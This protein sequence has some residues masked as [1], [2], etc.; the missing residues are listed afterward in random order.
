M[1][2]SVLWRNEL[3]RFFHQCHDLQSLRELKYLKQKDLQSMGLQPDIIMCRTE[4]PL[5]TEI[6]EK[7]ALFC[8]VSCNH[9]LQNLDAETLYEVPL[10]GSP[11]FDDYNINI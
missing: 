2:Y 4:F 9:V 3:P 6:R 10:I 8:N 5:Q 1:V 11:Y 7:I